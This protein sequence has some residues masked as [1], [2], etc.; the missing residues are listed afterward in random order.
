MEYRKQCQD[1]LDVFEEHL[2]SFVEECLMRHFGEK[3]WNTQVPESIAS[4]CKRRLERERS[5]RFPR[6]PASPPIDYT[7]MGN[8]KDIIC[9]RDNF[10]QVFKSFFSST[11]HISSRLELLI[12]FRN[13]AKH[14]RPIFGLEEYQNIIVTCRSIFD[15]M[16]LPRPAIFI[17]K[18]PDDLGDNT[19]E[20]DNQELVQEDIVQTPRCR[21]NLPRPDYSTFFG[22]NEERDEILAHLEHPRAWITII[23]G[24]GGVGKT[25][26]ALNC[27]EHIRDA[28]MSG[29]NE[30][31]N[32]VWASAKT[33]R[34]VPSGISQ[35][36]PTFTDLTSLLQLVLD[37]LGFSDHTP[38]DAVTLT[39]ELLAISK[40]LLVLDNLETVF[41]PTFYD[42]LQDVPAPSKVLATTRHRVEGSHKNLRLTAL[43]R[44]HA[45]DMIHQLASELDASELLEESDHSLGGLIDRVGGI[46]LAIRLAVGRIAT[47]LPLDSYL[48]KLDTGA[49][50]HD[51][52][53]FC[54]FESWGNL[55]A[56]AKLTLSC[57]VLFSEPPSQEELRIVTEI[58]EM[59]LKDAIGVL[60]RR[61]FLN[62]SYD[63]GNQTYRYSL[64]PL[65]ADFVRQETE[66]DPE[67]QSR[68]HDQYNSYLLE[69]GRFEEALGQITHLV[70]TTTS[71][72]EAERIASML[73]ESAFRTYQNGSYP[74]SVSRLQKAQSYKNTAY[75]NH[76]WG[77]IERDE[78]AYSTARDK[79]RQS[80]KLDESRLQT[81]RSWGRMEQRLENWQYAVNCFSHATKL[82]GSDPQDFHG[83]GVCLS[84]LAVKAEGVRRQ[85][86]LEEG[87]QALK[88]GFYKNPFGYRDTH[89]NV[90]N[91]HSLAL[92]LQRLDRTTEA[93]IQCRNGLRLEPN[94]IRLIDLN[95]SLTKK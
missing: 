20:D 8:L 36:L 70:P 79:F 68:L 78:G 64:L 80:V 34:L 52:L 13:P 54:F 60:L 3:W 81:W 75:L 77:V 17:S 89:H 24:I 7:D 41:D 59:R 27:A 55:D 65:T 5:Q 6:L 84:R 39:R 74:D 1:A 66:L 46:P 23:D 69:K 49:A 85:K 62:S 32:V 87:E 30:F 22:R 45:L 26:L 29:Q 18:P 4:E 50:Q 88:Q 83:L 67:L 33:E 72:S 2:R 35:V 93:L 44:Q 15:A 92:T 19:E 61:A 42:F 90:V 51:L 9:K 95:Q 47:G 86:L 43:P 53:T 73:V 91:C 28:S 63:T 48:D 11:D 16:D 58:P 37:A 76:T 56:S 21:D 82:V 12:A 38:E 94:N 14:V 71:M 25:A 10:E 57:T 40:T 31:E